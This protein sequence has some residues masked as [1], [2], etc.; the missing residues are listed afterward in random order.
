MSNG[1][2]ELELLD[3]RQTEESVQQ[4]IKA[5]KNFSGASGL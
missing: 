3:R 4:T 2:Y 5:F 1:L